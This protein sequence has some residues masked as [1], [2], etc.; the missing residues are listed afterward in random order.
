MKLTLHMGKLSL[1]AVHLPSVVQNRDSN[2]NRRGSEDH[3]AI[4]KTLGDKL[5]FPSGGKWTIPGTPHS[6]GARTRFVTF[7]WATWGSQDAYLSNG[8]ADDIK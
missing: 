3:K 6:E 8:F 1:K 4:P 7:F 5:E 2:S